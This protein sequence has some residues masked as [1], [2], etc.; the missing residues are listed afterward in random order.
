MTHV[1]RMFQVLFPDNCKV[2]FQND[3]RETNVSGAVY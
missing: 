3:A 1:K 2:F